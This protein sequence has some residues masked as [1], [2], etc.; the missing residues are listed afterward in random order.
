MTDADVRTIVETTA[1]RVVRLC[2]RRGLFEEGAT[3][4][5]WEQDPL[6]AQ[7]SA[8]SVQGMVG[9]QFVDNQS[10][11]QHVRQGHVGGGDVDATLCP[12]H[13]YPR[14]TRLLR[15]RILFRSC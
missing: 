10:H 13:Y 8:A 9:H 12:Y 6:L 7:I 1:Q 11:G 14:Q 4:P 3:D 2:Q 5:F 15:A